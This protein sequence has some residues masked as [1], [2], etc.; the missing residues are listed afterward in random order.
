MNSKTLKV[1]GAVGLSLFAMIIVVTYTPKLINELTEERETPNEARETLVGTS[2]LDLSDKVAEKALAALETWSQME[3]DMDKTHT[4][5][6]TEVSVA[7]P[8]QTRQ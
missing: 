4:E 1:V 3:S 8:R 5:K 7:M 2:H 6:S